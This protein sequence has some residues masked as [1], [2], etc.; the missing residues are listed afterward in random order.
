MSTPLPP[1]DL[2]A[3]VLGTQGT[4][5]WTADDVPTAGSMG[6]QGAQAYCRI[7]NE[8]NSGLLI[9]FATG[10]GEHLPAGGWWVTPI[11]SGAYSFRYTVEYQLSSPIVTVLLVTL[12][13]P[14]EPV[15]P[16]PT[17]G[18]SPI[19]GGSIQTTGTSADQ[20]DSRYSAN[21]T[22]PQVESATVGAGLGVKDNAGAIELYPTQSDSTARSLRLDY[23]DSAGALHAG[24]QVRKA[25]QGAIPAGGLTHPSGND[26]TWGSCFNG[27]ATGTYSHNCQQTPIWIGITCDNLNSSETVG[28]DSIGSSTVHVTVG[29]ALPWIGHAVV[30]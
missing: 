29:A 16:P 10:Q 17:L 21:T 14:G 11:P 27:S 19:G 1:I 5:N 4:V 3:A 24:P 12:Y 26:L 15:P 9:E 13:A 6:T 22:T 25:A 20:V 30:N 7:F 28:V 2:S 23:I 18:N 8:S